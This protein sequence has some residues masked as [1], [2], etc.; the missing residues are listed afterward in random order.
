MM[1]SS[2]AEDPLMPSSPCRCSI[3]VV[4]DFCKLCRQG[5]L[6]GL[7]ARLLPDWSEQDVL[8]GGISHLSWSLAP[9][10]LAVCISS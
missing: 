9:P 7:R 6:G 2:T 5:R 1:L 3:Q 4:V 10:S 8:D